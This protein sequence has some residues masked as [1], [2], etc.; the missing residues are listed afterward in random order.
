MFQYKKLDILNNVYELLDAK[1]WL[2]IYV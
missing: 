1:T 2:Y